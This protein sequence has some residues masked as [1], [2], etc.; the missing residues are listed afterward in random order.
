MTTKLKRIEVE[1]KGFVFS[2]VIPDFEDVKSVAEGLDDVPLAV[3]D[4][5]SDRPHQPTF[6][7]RDAQEY[8]NELLRIVRLYLEDGFVPG[9]CDRPGLDLKLLV[10]YYDE[11]DDIYEEEDEFEVRVCSEDTEVPIRVKVGDWLVAGLG[12]VRFGDKVG[13][14]LMEE[15]YGLLKTVG[16][17]VLERVSDIRELERVAEDL[18]YENYEALKPDRSYLLVSYL[19]E[20]LLGTVYFHPDS[21]CSR[22][23]AYLTFEGGEDNEEDD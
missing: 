14:S 6:F 10:F 9:G 19:P 21:P 3:S 18:I 4:G 12:V 23:V 1:H 16:N 7:A 20:R 22:E 17:R 15:W 2:V 13:L 8:E 11:E 5:F